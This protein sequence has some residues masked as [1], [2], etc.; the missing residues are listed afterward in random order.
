MMPAIGADWYCPPGYRLT[1]ITRENRWWKF[2]A[3]DS[4]Q[5]CQH[6]VRDSLGIRC[7]V[8]NRLIITLAR[9]V[10]NPDWF[11]PSIICEWC[12]KKVK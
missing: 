9:M 4:C 11:K 3:D 6:P 10:E 8:N 2:W 12:P 1:P 7:G 5:R